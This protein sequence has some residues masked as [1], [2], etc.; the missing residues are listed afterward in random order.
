[1]DTDNVARLLS[2]A[3]TPLNTKSKDHPRPKEVG[4]E[5]RMDAEGFLGAPL[6]SIE[7]SGSSHA[8]TFDA[9]EVKSTEDP[10]S[11][12]QVASCPLSFALSVSDIAMMSVKSF[13]STEGDLAEDEGKEEARSVISISSTSEGLTREARD[14]SEAPKQPAEKPQAS[15]PDHKPS[16]GS[17]GQESA[18]SESLTTGVIPRLP[19]PALSLDHS[20]V[21]DD[22]YRQH[23]RALHWALHELETRLTTYQHLEV[24]LRRESCAISTAM[25]VREQEKYWKEDQKASSSTSSPS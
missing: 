19:I 15:S 12:L 10:D 3:E 16:S 18:F 24:L 9:I 7:T 22:Y 6:R 4:E 21:A 5:E 1:M 2:S 17:N 13:A 20:V 11:P 14:K 23:V 8:V 25:W